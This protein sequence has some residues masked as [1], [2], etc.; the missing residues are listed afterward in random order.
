MRCALLHSTT[1]HTQ[2]GIFHDPHSNF[3]TPSTYTITASP[4]H[5]EYLSSLPS[6][7]NVTFDIVVGVLSLFLQRRSEGQY[8]VTSGEHKENRPLTNRPSAC[9]Q[10][11]VCHG[12]SRDETKEFATRPQETESIRNLRR[13]HA[14]NAEKRSAGSDSRAREE[15]TR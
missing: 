8:T 5:P 1:L 15:A 13:L 10:I 2:Y 6:P 14:M 12:W 3:P 9:G 11:R 4:S 7:L